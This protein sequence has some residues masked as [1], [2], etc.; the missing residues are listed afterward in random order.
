MSLKTK[1]HKLFPAIPKTNLAIGQKLYALKIK[2]NEGNVIQALSSQTDIYG[3]IGC[4]GVGL[5]TGWVNIDFS[6]YE[7][8]T[9]GFDCRKNLPFADNSA[10][11][12]YTEHF[13][14]HLDYFTEVPYFLAS[15]YRSLQKGGVLRIVVPDAEKYLRGYCT[16]NWD[17]LKRTRPLNN[18]LYDEGMG[19]KFE[20]K[21]QLVNEVFRQGGD[22]K[23]AWDYETLKLSLLKAGFNLTHK[24]SYMQSNDAKLQIDQANREP[25]S[26]YVE[27]IK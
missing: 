7:N 1:I 12:L 22:H 21:M 23:Y 15:C 19:I 11:G 18:D 14:E 13:F 4:G 16:D 26:L 27:A 5:P 3:N 17:E 25:E 6:I 9:Y 2:R 24:M 10:K 20:T 8:V